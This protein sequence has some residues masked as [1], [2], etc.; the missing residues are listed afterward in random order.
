MRLRDP[1]NAKLYGDIFGPSLQGSA[2]SV[3]RTSVL[4]R[5]Q[6]SQHVPASPE[7]RLNSKTPAEPRGWWLRCDQPDRA[8]LA[9]ALF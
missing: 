2:V 3:R 1:T 6:A 4:D 9:V 7:E 8:V 5:E